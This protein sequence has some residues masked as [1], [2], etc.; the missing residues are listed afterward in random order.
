MKK[1]GSFLSLMIV[2][3]VLPEPA[4]TLLAVLSI[5]CWCF[6]RRRRERRPALCDMTIPA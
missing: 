5:G 6:L 3:T 1:R 2:L 4:T